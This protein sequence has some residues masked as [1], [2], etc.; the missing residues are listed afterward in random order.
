VPPGKETQSEAYAPV[1][2]SKVI[3]DNVTVVFLASIAL[4]PSVRV[5]LIQF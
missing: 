4:P 5:K 3:T 1:N 2:I